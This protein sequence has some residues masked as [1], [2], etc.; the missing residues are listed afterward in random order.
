MPRAVPLALISLALFAAGCGGSS[1]SGGDDP[2]SAVPAGASIYA[3]ATLRPEGSLR[4]D[5]LAAAGKVL[6]TSDPQSE[7]DE[8]VRKAFAESEDPKL[9]YERD[10]APW[11]GEKVAVWLAPT[12]GE[13]DFR[14]A[15]VAATKDEDEAQAAIDR[16]VKGSDKT[17]SSRTY[18]DVEYQA[19]TDSAAG[20]VEGFAVFG[21]EPEFKKTVDAAKGDGLAADDRFEKAMDGLEDDRLGSFYFDLRAVIDQAVREEPESAEQLEQFKQFFPVDKIGPVAGAFMANGERLAV[22]A[23]A[24][25]PEGALPG[26]LGALTGGGSTPL[27]GELPGDSWVA[28]GSP[29]FGQSVKALYE[30]VAGALGGAAIEGQLRQELGLDLQ[31]DVFSWIGDVAFFARG[32]TKDTIEGGAVIEVTDSDAAKAAF[33]KLIGL[34]QSQGDVAARP[35]RIDGAETAFEAAAPGAPKP[36]VAARSDDRVVIA[37][38]RSAAEDA[39]GG[40]DRLGESELFGAAKGVLGDDVEPGFLLSMPAVLELVRAT[41]E[42]DADFEKAEPYLEAFGVLAGGSGRDGDTARSRFAAELK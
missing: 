34:A 28:L 22:D 40:G 30:Q 6:R 35:V 38:G 16:A 36:I 8:L 33:P 7:I 4:E 20:I 10:V 26:G 12:S 15:I 39:L 18:K 14:G 2:A 25:V 19:S 9:D 21:T 31:K 42:A 27:L 5:A 11:L 1:A 32:T 17:F 24:S 23:V 29:D 41:G 37:L 3:D 13:E